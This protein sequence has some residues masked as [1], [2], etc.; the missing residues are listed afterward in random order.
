GEFQLISQEIK[1][2][3]LNF[4]ILIAKRRREP[5]RWSTAITMPV[6]QKHILSVISFC[7]SWACPTARFSSPDE[8]L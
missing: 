7:F 3:D 1:K 2:Y 5:D 8:K 6:L 4:V